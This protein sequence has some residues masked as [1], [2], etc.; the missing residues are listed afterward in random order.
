[1]SKQ[2]GRNALL[3]SFLGTLLGGSAHA[4][5]V[6]YWRFESDSDAGATSAIVP[7]EVAGGSTL[8]SAS[9]TLNSQVPSP[10]IKD[11]VAGVNRTNVNSGNGNAEFNATAAHYAALNTGS[12][13]VE[14]FFRTQETTGT[15]IARSNNT[16]KG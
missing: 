4:A 2:F 12:I 11:P 14:G 13:T 6:G 7:N 16:A 15:L 9:M 8:V 1:M 10:E 3:G 5:T